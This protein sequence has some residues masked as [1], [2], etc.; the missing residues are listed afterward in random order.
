MVL[1][2]A[3]SFPI[4]LGPRRLIKTTLHGS[5][6]TQLYALV[7]LVLEMFVGVAVLGLGVLLALF[8]FRRI[9]RTLPLPPG[10][11]KLPILGNLL[12]IP[13]SFEWETFQRWG[14]ECSQFISPFFIAILIPG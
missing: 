6:F 3:L 2:C 12:H 5:P 8:T 10:P 9:R 7:F 14:E 11:R 1:I 13:T 4:L